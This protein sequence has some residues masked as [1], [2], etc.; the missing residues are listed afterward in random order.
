[1]RLLNQ[2]IN[3]IADFS[4]HL[5]SLLFFFVVLQCFEMKTKVCNKINTQIK[6]PH[7]K[8]G[9]PIKTITNSV[10]TTR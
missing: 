7:L 10:Q 6:K 3:S 1:M 8:K 9:F 4:P 5:G 2:S